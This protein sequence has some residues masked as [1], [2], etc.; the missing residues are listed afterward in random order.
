M[1]TACGFTWLSMDANSLYLEQA[2]FRST[3]DNGGKAVQN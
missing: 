1:Q 2:S 3:F